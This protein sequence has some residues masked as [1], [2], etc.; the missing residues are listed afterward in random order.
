MCDVRGIVAGV[1][2]L[3]PA[4]G[5]GVSGGGGADV[6]TGLREL[7]LRD[8]RRVWSVGSGPSIRRPLT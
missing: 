6:P 1:G 3:S 4:A 2:F 7:R 8:E 5:R